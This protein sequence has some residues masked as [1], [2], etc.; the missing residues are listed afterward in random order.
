MRVRS[1][2]LDHYRLKPMEVEVAL[3]PGLS[4]VQITGLPDTITRESGI[5]IKSAV[6]ACG[7]VW[8]QAQKVL[9]NLR[10]SYI[11]KPSHGLDIAIAVAYLQV[12]HQLDLDAI[13]EHTGAQQ[14]FFYGELGLD[15]LA[16]ALPELEALIDLEGLLIT[17]QGRHSLGV[18]SVA[19]QS[20]KDLSQ[21]LE[22]QPP[23]PDPQIDRPAVPNYLFSDEACQAMS[24]AALGGHSILLAG[25]AGT[26]KT[27]VAESLHTLMPDVRPKQWR[28]MKAVARIFGDE[29]KWRPFIAP[30]HSSPVKCLIGGSNTARAGE[31]TRAHGGLLFL[32]EFLEF[33]HEVREALREPVEKAFISVARLGHRCT[34][35]ADFQLVAATNLCPCGDFCPGQW[36]Q[37]CNY[38]LHRCRAYLQRLSGPMLDRFQMVSF[39][40]Q[41]KGEKKHSLQHIL[42]SVQKAQKFIQTRV[43]NKN[44]VQNQVNARADIKVLEKQ[45][46]SPKLE[47][48]LPH[49]EGLSM[50]RRDALFRVARSVADLNES[51]CITPEHIGTAAG[52][53]IRPM[54]DIQQALS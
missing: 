33:K 25:P 7:F 16:S 5:R 36:S 47:A 20:L 12:T 54:R 27:T 9:V 24:I 43:T 39:S 17:G 53:T 14:L 38:S 41:W 21:S 11:S 4:Q 10:P 23:S 3:Q 28:H 26:G 37:N 31:L 30:H 34:Y 29:L 35:P 40:H 52:Y 42:Q 44:E 50:R 46:Q 49:I 18:P 6:Q 15:G 22:V 32:D 48:V 13:G 51:L 1:F 19:L 2:Y 8:P 45:M